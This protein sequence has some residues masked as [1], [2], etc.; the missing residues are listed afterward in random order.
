MSLSRLPD[1]IMEQV[2]SDEAFRIHYS[3]A[4]LCPVALVNRWFNRLAL[5]F[6]YRS[7]ALVLGGSRYDG[8]LCTLR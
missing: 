6:L 2:L 8:L 4:G 7:V 3:K 1:E 5:P